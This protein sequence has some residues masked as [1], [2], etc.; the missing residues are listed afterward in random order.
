MNTALLL[1]LLCVSGLLLAF[2]MSRR[3]AIYEFPFLAGT[4]FGGFMVPQLIGLLN[5]PFLPRGALEKTLVMAVLSAAMCWFGHALNRHPLRML[6]WHFDRTR[7]LWASG[8]LSLVGSYFYFALGRLPEELTDSTQWSGL[9][10]AYL[11][12]ARMLTYGF[13]IAVIVYMHS[14]SKVALMLA[15]FD[16]LFYLER[17]VIAGRRADLVEFAFIILLALWFQRNRSVPRGAMLA[18]VIAGALFVNSIGDYRGAM[19]EAR[20][21]WWDAVS[22]IDY[23]GNLEK[24]AEQGGAELKNAVYN[25]EAISRTMRFD[26]GAFHWNA[27]VFSYVPAQLVGQGF[28]QSLM[29]PMENAAYLEFFYSPRLGTTLTGLTDAFGSFWYFGCLKFFA[30]AFIMSKLYMAA[31]RD[32]FAAQLVYSLIVPAAM[33]AI[34]HHTQVF[35]SPWIHMILF[36]LPALLFARTRRKLPQRAGPMPQARG[37]RDGNPMRGRDRYRPLPLGGPREEPC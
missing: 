13:A 17:I 33:Q 16:S 22:N 35:V 9:P 10:V 12:F 36:L 32:S 34:T 31:R 28:K 27:L 2:G 15:L 19:E 37:G 30:I 20:G 18:A 21:S 1:I 24:I 26:Y 3:G 5:D 25:I 14:A 6:D 7:L 23:V 8:G 4:V 11:F 29:I